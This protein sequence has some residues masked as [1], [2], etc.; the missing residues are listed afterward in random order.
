LSGAGDTSEWQSNLLALQIMRN[1]NTVGPDYSGRRD[2]GRIKVFRDASQGDS[3]DIEEEV[4]RALRSN[5][6]IDLVLWGKSY[7]INGAAV[8]QLYL[9]LRPS[10]WRNRAN[11]HLWTLSGVGKEVA[12]EFPATHFEFEP[13]VLPRNIVEQFSA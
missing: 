7:P 6:A 3:S 5:P 2:P 11:L 12:V 4:E 1:I 8:I 9:S 10:A 13:I